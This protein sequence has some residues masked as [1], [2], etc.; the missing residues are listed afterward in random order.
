M[1]ETPIEPGSLPADPWSSSVPTGT[2]FTDHA[3][4]AA[5]VLPR[6]VEVATADLV[7]SE[8]STARPMAALSPRRS[9]EL[10][11]PELIGNYR[12]LEELGAGA[13]GTVYR[14]RQESLARDIALKVLAPH[15][16]DDAELVERFHREARAAARLS[17]PN[18]VQAYETGVHGTLWHYIAMEWVDG[19]SVADVMAEEGP[20]S[21]PRALGIVADVAGALGEIASAGMVH[22]DV[23]PQNILIA[24]GGVAKLSDLGLSKQLCDPSGSLTQTGMVMGTPHYMAPEQA[25]GKDIDV[26]SDIYALGISLYRM[27]TG[28]FPFEGEN[29]FVILQRRTQEDVPDPRTIRPELSEA[30]AELL[31]WMTEREPIDRPSNGE[32]LVDGVLAILH[33]ERGVSSD[34]EYS[35][36]ITDETERPRRRRST[37]EQKV[38]RRSP[39]P[40]GRRRSS[41]DPERRRTRR[42][43]PGASGTRRRRGPRRA[44]RVAV[45]KAAGHEP[46]QLVWLLAGAGA[47]VGVLVLL[48]VLRGQLDGSAAPTPGDG[49]ATTTSG[50]TGA[51]ATAAPPAGD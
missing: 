48:L 32:E 28:L 3:T 21:E 25:M 47:V 50:E 40:D 49:A 31:R 4:G 13:M 24:P 23:K 17:H 39:D 15:L 42:N 1:A 46:S 44:S 41:P 36:S 19:P 29:V 6:G 27:L 30:T 9:G 11:P 14:A 16:I 34:A 38:A 45:R 5:A 10:E 51:P 37:G 18:V 20:L 12:V 7:G 2:R 8:V 35:S 33:P 43:L 22:R 26:R